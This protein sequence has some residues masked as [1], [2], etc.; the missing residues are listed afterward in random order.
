MTGRVLCTLLT[1]QNLAWVGAYTSVF[2]LIAIAIVQRYFAVVHA[3]GN[4]GKLTM[5]KLNVCY[6]GIKHLPDVTGKFVVNCKN[7]NY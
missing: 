1:G 3:Y 6:F 7:A 2:T 5:R 4:K